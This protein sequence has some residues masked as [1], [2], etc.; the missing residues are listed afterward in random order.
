M[1]KTHCRDEEQPNGIG[2][3]NR[4]YCGCRCRQSHFRNRSVV[5]SYPSKTAI[6][7]IDT[8]AAQAAA[9]DIQ[10]AMRFATQNLQEALRNGMQGAIKIGMPGYGQSVRDRAATSAQSSIQSTQS[11]GL[12]NGATDKDLGK[13]PGS[14]REEGSNA[15]SRTGSRDGKR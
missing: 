6:G 11:A 2:V 14:A 13:A 3:R 8:S 4:E 5:K 7:P 12:L 1:A 15:D 10:N 9:R